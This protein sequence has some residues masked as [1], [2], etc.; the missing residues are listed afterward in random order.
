MCNQCVPSNYGNERLHAIDIKY[1]D[2]SMKLVVWLQIRK[3]LVQILA[4]PTFLIFI[5]SF[6]YMS[7]KCT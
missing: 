1:V 3:L 4:D 5:F 7:K 6:F 2:I